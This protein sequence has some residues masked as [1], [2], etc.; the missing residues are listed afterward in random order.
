M[1]ET[2]PERIQFQNHIFKVGD[3]I[4]TDLIFPTKHA[5]DPEVDLGKFALTGL[6]DIEP[7]RLRDQ[8]INVISAGQHFGCGSAREQAPLSLQAAGVQLIL[9]ESL[10]PIFKDNCAKIGLLYSTDAS[11][12]PRLKAGEPIPRQKII[13]SLPQLEA[14]MFK[15]DGLIGLTIAHQQGE[16]QLSTLDTKPR[17]QTMIEKLIA[18]KQNQ[19][20]YPK[21]GDSV[22]VKPDLL[23]S[24]EFFTSL[25][26]K[27]LQEK[28]LKPEEI[29]KLILFSDH[30]VGSQI[31]AAKDLLAHHAAL[32]RQHKAKLYPYCWE[33]K[34]SSGVG[35]SLLAELEASPGNIVLMTDSH[36]PNIAGF[37]GLGLATSI[38]GLTAALAT[39][40]YIFT[41]PETVRVQTKG[42]FKDQTTA[43]DLMLYLLNLNQESGVINDSCVEFGGPGLN[44]LMPDELSVLSNLAVEAHSQTAVIEP[45]S[46]QL[47]VMA[48]LTNQPLDQVIKAAE[49]LKPDPRAEYKEVINV[50][51]DNI[52]PMVA[53]PGSPANGQEIRKIARRPYM[54]KVYIGSCVG[55]TFSSLVQAAKIL[56]DKKVHPQ[57]ELYIQPISFIIYQALHEAGLIDVFQKAGAI[58]LPPACGACC[59]LG[60]GSPQP[61]ENALFV[62]NRNWEGRNKGKIYLAS[63]LTAAATAIKGH[64]A[65]PEEI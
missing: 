58:V 11:L 57:T 43:F 30:T 8:N 21:S 53:L 60:P 33:E 25:I 55:G 41:I 24:Y 44:N 23:A 47:E 36:T 61:G 17:P 15:H 32:A 52:E 22:A 63:S 14:D 56:K 16:Y 4:N 6:P 26:F 50:N 9:A 37:L 51:L 7:G 18:Q 10:D 35:H 34:A 1:V 46:M 5:F 38:T 40:E 29:R 54:Q 48:K 39:G 45:T 31:P 42:S 65:V 59:G 27:L 12:L 2:R 13:D 49:S 64:L 20:V 3:N 28:N 62:S 19:Q